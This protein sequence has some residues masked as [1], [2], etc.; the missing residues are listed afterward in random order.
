M[1]E[2]IRGRFLGRSEGKVLVDVGNIVLGIICDAESFSETTEGEEVVVYTK[3]IVSQEDM[4]IY[5]FN[6]KEK[7]DVFEKLIKVS[8]LGPKSAIKI[9]SSASIELLSTAIANGDIERL[10]SIPGI[11]K[12]TA[13]RIVA[14]L[15]DE[16][17]PM[18]VDEVSLEAIEALVSLGYA[19][20]QAQN[21]VK[22]ARKEFP[23]ASLSKL[24]KESLK[25]LSK[26]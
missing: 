7:R 15:K 4:S 6:S 3:L 13:E 20:S 22:H 23:D 25:I 24:I 9:L 11:G 12:K 26:M 16:F 14:E 2:Q 8:K 18:Q 10:S 17:E 1:I 19:K 21:A 5:G